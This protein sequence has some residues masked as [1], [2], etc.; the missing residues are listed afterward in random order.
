MN[1]APIRIQPHLDDEGDVWQ[2]HLPRRRP[3]DNPASEYLVE[4]RHARACD[5]SALRQA[6]EIDPRR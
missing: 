3:H 5:M 6:D 4:Y 1:L 2:A